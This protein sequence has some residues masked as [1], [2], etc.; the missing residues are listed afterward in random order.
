M[1]LS[2]FTHKTRV[3]CLLTAL[4]ALTVMQVKAHVF[5][6]DFLEPHFMEYEE[7]EAKR[8][9]QEAYEKDFRGEPLTEKEVQR[10]CE[11]YRDLS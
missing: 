8:E 10:C 4:G 9:R 5:D 2:V 3:A 6:F 1:N 7:K 11:Y